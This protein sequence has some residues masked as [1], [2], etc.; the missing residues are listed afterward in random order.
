M[1]R[2]KANAVSEEALPISGDMLSFIFD[3]YFE[4]EAVP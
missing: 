1:K 4:R 2:N 3:I